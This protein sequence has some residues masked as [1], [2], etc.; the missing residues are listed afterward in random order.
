MVVFNLHL[1]Y[2]QL[3]QLSDGCFDEAEDIVLMAPHF[4]MRTRDRR[5]QL[6][7][8]VRLTC[9][10]IGRPKPEV[11]WYHRYQSVD[12]PIE[13]SERHEL[14]V[15]GDFHTLEI[16]SSRFDDAGI[17]TV[18]ATNSQVCTNQHLKRSFCRGHA[19]AFAPLLQV[20]FLI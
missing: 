19:L 17:Y 1:I 4:T 5:V 20:I 15:D 9:Q 16:S 8:P 2:R 18:R 3:D 12:V 6:A 11:T 14:S 13:E 7:H 10:V